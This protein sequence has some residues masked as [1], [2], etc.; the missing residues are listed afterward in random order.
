MMFSKL[1]NLAGKTTAVAFC[2]AGAISSF[3]QPI[4]NDGCV[5]GNFGIDAGLYSNTL[6][7]GNH[8][9]VPAAGTRDWFYSAGTGPG[10]IN[11]TNASAIQ[12]L[13][14]GGGN[15]TYE[16]R[17]YTGLSSIV[18]NQ[19]LIDAIWVRDQFGGSG[20]VDATAY[21]TAS[22]NG[23]DPAI[24]DPGPMKVLGKNDLI[25][26]SGHM[27]RDGTAL[28]G[29][30]PPSSLWFVGLI[31]RAEPGGSAYMDFE[32]YVEEVS[33]SPSTGFSS[34]GPQ[35]GHTAFTFNPDGSIKTVGDMIFN[36]SLEAGVTPG[37]ELRLWVSRAD[38]DANLHPPGFNWGPLYDG[39]FT[40]SPYGYANVVPVSS[41]VCGIVNVEGQHPACPP[42]GTKGTK[43]NSYQTTYSDYSVVELGMNMT[44]FGVDHAT[45]QGD[46]CDFPLRSFIVK[47]R[48]SNS[49]TAQL[50]DFAGP[51][52]WGQPNFV[53]TIVGNPVLACDNP[54][55][56]LTPSPIRPDVIYSWTTVDGNILGDPNSATIQANEP[57]TYDLHAILP[58]T[59]PVANDA[60]VIVDYDPL[61]PFFNDLTGVGTVAC[62]GTNGSINLDVSGGTAPFTYQWAKDP[63]PTIIS[64]IQDPTGLTAGTY[65]V[66]VTDALGCTKMGTGITVGARVPTVIGTTPTTV[67][68]FGNSTGS[69]DASVTGQSPFTYLWST[70]STS[71]EIFGLS[72]GTYTL[73][74]TDADGCT[75]THSTAVIQ[76]TAL[77]LPFIKSDDTDPNTTANG[78]IDLTVSGGISG[79]TY[80]WSNNGAQDPD[81]DSQDLTSVEAGTY[82]VTVTDANGCT[83]TTSVTIYE[84]E[85]CNDSIDNDGDGLSDCYDSECVPAN[86]GAVTASLNPVCVGDTGITYTVPS[87]VGYTYNWTVPAGATITSGTGTNQI[88]VS[89]TSNIGGQICVESVSFGCTSTG[90]TCFSVTLNDIPPQPADIIKG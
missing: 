78:T 46:D 7:F 65:F 44:T 70:G 20:A 28:V 27:F 41:Q 23:E 58:T 88:T 5:G 52:V 38:Y 1:I 45:L 21:E 42:W 56:T 77:S 68:C 31:N 18:N 17:M 37:V 22:K 33:Y 79:Y 63:S 59:C 34:G 82:T 66:T 50:K 73:T 67:D 43:D 47:T 10:T 81:T 35:L 40:G 61:K 8:S 89:W 29:A 3:G 69:I 14:Q 26:V 84:P 16:R 80:D 25:D 13:L 6:E 71:D 2:L 36:V 60:T 85:K 30:D 74:T 87:V 54:V 86:P 53:P 51:Y 75:E 76:P 55:V 57:G 15:P 4:D 19:I 64:T 12:S 48:A 90:Q 9:S 32:F 72:A 49:F 83:T 39:A 11:E 62:S 24:W